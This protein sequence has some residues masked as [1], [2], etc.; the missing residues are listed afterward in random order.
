[1]KPTVRLL[2]LVCVIGG[3]TV[4]EAR[5][6]NSYSVGVE[7]FRD[8]YKEYCVDGAGV[9]PKVDIHTD[10]GSVTASYQHTAGSYFTAIDGRYSQGDADYKSLSGTINNISDKEGEARLRFG[11]NMVAWHGI[12]MPYIGVGARLFFDQGK[13]MFSSI[14]AEAYDRHITQLYAPLGVTYQFNWGS[15]V[16]R[17]N[18]E[19]DAL[20]WGKV[21]SHLGEVR[22][23]YN[24]EN[25]QH[26]GVGLRGEFMAGQQYK[27]FGWEI[28]PFVRYWHVDASDIVSTPATPPGTGLEEPKNARLQVGGAL[29]VNF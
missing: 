9:D 26:G 24:V 14:G 19:V 27:Y 8:A 15:W 23:N 16:F 1:M 22:G 25:T 18:A 4:S 29:R 17:P 3:V 6:D 20:F 5:A 28:G 2:S 21:E 7:G 10:Y 13:G 12:V 11:A